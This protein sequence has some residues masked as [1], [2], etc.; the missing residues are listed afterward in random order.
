M[1]STIINDTIYYKSRIPNAP[2]FDL[3]YLNLGFYLH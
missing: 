3:I 1:N 2:T